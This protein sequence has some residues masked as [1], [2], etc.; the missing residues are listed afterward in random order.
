MQP[1]EGSTRADSAAVDFRQTY[2][3]KR[4]KLLDP[5]L[6]KCGCN[7]KFKTRIPEKL[8]KNKT[9]EN[10]YKKRKQRERK[11]TNVLPHARGT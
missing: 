7:E 4:R 6:C 11:K 8:F 1:H 9:H 2:P 10:R 3:H 5:R